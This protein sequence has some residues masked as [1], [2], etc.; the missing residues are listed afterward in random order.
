[1]KIRPPLEAG[2][3]V[4][5]HKNRKFSKTEKFIVKSFDLTEDTTDGFTVIRVL[6][7][8]TLAKYNM[9]RKDL[10][11]TGANVGKLKAQKVKQQLSAKHNS[12]PN[13]ASSEKKCSC[14]LKTIMEHGCQCGGS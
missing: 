14:D 9:R 10:W 12:V 5:K 2:D 13:T 7:T 6:S 4:I 1:M 8:K 11:K 3:I